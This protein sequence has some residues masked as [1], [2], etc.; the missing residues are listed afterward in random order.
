MGK[1]KTNTSSWLSSRKIKYLLCTVSLWNYLE[2]H[3]FIQGQTAIPEDNS[4]G[5]SK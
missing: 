2:K 5:K 3:I 1:I 4:S